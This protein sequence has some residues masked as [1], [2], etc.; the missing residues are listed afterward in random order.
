MIKRKLSAYKCFGPTFGGKG[1]SSIGERGKMAVKGIHFVSYV[2]GLRHCSIFL[3]QTKAAYV[4]VY[5]RR[6][7]DGVP[8]HV[9]NKSR[10]PPSATTTSITAASTTDG[11]TTVNGYNSDDEMDTNWR[12]YKLSDIMCECSRDSGLQTLLHIRKNSLVKDEKVKPDRPKFLPWALAAEKTS[13]R[14][15]PDLR[16]LRGILCA[17]VCMFLQSVSCMWWLKVT[18]WKGLFL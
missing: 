6:G 18:E 13:R 10:P 16:N 1:S 14:K 5:Q 9:P 17:W 11:D 3:L 12:P 8:R 4:L 15:W 2:S 7:P